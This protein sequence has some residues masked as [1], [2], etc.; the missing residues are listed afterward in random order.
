MA[1]RTGGNGTDGLEGPGAPRPQV[2]ASLTDQHVLAAVLQAP[3]PIS[4]AEVA[5][6]SG[7]SK[8]AVSA[9]AARLLERGLLHDVGIREGRRGGVATLLQ[10]NAS[11]GHS[12]ALA[13]QPN[14]V[15]LVASDLAGLEIGALD[16]ALHEGASRQHVLDVVRQG[17][18][19]IEQSAG[20]PL[21]AV[22]VSLAG[23]VDVRT[24]EALDL[25]RATFPAGHL[26]PHADLHLDP[27]LPLA[28]DNDVNWASTAE[29]RDGQA[30]HVQDF[31]Y[32]YCGS[33]IGAALFLDGR[34]YR[35][36]SGLGGEIGYLRASPTQDLT[37]AIAALGTA[38][39]D[40]YGLDV[41]AVDRLFTD[42]TRA[43]DAGTVSDLVAAAIANLAIAVNPA[44]VLL[45]GPW[46][47]HSLLGQR[48]QAAVAAH[49]LDTPSVA[50]AGFDPLRGAR[51][52]A[53]RLACEQVGLP[54][55]GSAA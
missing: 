14:A 55:G 47:T 37:E 21:L 7:L 6:R 48:V 11:H 49:C 5:A 40:G 4:R 54:V 28:V 42:P 15:R 17:I 44:A 19:Y 20:T 1:S 10:I 27:D 35:G 45:A 31:I 36:R 43:G 39:V 50:L 30:R 26:D 9:A 41:A 2:L 22:A 24:G 18:K 51:Q 32:V 23:P 12:L 3:E 16:M 8:P 46:T 34:L 13:V 33:G 25:Q 38:H 29:H 52:H 53:H